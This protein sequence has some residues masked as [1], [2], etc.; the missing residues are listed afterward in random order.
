M[1]K[2]LNLQRH[3]TIRFFWRAMHHKADIKSTILPK[4]FEQQ[5]INMQYIYQHMCW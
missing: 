5:F 2:I 3:S 4:T 1:G